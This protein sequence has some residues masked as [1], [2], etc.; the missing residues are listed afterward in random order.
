MTNWHEP[1]FTLTPHDGSA[2]IHFSITKFDK[3]FAEQP[4]LFDKVEVSLRA[5]DIAFLRTNN[6]V[7]QCGLDRLPDAALDR[8]GYMVVFP[9][10]TV[11]LVDGNHRAVKRFEK[12][13]RTMKMGVLP[14]S[15]ALLHCSADIPEFLRPAAERLAREQTPIREH[16]G[17]HFEQAHRKE[18]K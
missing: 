17:S 1:I 6:G 15:L 4:G 7:E 16:Y 10:G 9:D 11:T 18:K 3:L 2:P 8:P 12:G 14:I 5:E 13:Y